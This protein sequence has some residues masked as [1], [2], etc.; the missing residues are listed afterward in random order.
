MGNNEMGQWLGVSHHIGILMSYWILTK[1]GCVISCTTV[2]HIPNL[3]LQTNEVLALC[4]NFDITFNA[5][6]DNDNFVLHPVSGTLLQYWQ[7]MDID[8]GPDFVA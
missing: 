5:L 3:E 2:Q 6:L 8:H 4:C 7:D 1:S